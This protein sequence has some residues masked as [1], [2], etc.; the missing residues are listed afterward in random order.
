MHEVIC[1]YP[2]LFFQ[3]FTVL[4]IKPEIEEACL[5]ESCSAEQQ[6]R[7]LDESGVKEEPGETEDCEAAPLC[8]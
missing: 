2:F 6:G 5:E 4:K 8:C 7:A 3:A 1:R